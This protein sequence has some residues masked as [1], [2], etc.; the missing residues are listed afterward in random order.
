M[1]CSPF[2]ESDF[3]QIRAEREGPA[4]AMAPPKAATYTHIYTQNFV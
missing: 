4:G 2:F 1:L 3:G